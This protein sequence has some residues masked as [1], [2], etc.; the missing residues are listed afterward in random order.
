[1]SAAPAKRS[2]TRVVS[3]FV[4]T[5]PGP[6]TTG[7]SL[8]AAT[9]T[10]TEAD[11]RAYF[12]ENQAQ[13]PQV[14]PMIRFEHVQLAPQASDSAKAAALAET[15]RLLEMVISGEDFADLATRFSHGPSSSVGG[16]LGWIRRD[17]SMVAEFEDAAF[18]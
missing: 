2:M 1:M 11:A 5:G 7:G 4:E 12:D 14:P 16:E 8:T 13:M 15:E 3:S 6:G 10:V 9:V 18:Q 17:G